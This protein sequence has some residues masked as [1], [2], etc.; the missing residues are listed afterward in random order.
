MTR[1]ERVGVVR[2]I[3]DSGLFQARNAMRLVAK[4]LG[5]SRASIYNLLAEANKTA[6]KSNGVDVGAASRIQRANAIAANMLGPKPN[7]RVRGRSRASQ[8]S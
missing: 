4:I 3:N 6:P 8:T 2:V 7:A 5:M 1:S